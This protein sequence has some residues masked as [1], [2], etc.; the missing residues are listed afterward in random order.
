MHDGVNEEE[1]TVK[2]GGTYSHL[3]RS[4]RSITE[5]TERKISTNSTK[6]GFDDFAAIQEIGVTEVEQELQ[7]QSWQRVGIRGKVFNE[8]YES[9]KLEKRQ[10]KKS[11]KVEELKLQKQQTNNTA[12]NN[13]QLQQTTLQITTQTTT[14]NISKI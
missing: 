7:Q 12:L 9:K 10:K 13:L 11:K 5:P 4:G 8:A 2:C 3:L 1:D 6:N 14:L